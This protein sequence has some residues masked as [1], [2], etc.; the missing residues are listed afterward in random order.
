MKQFQ[1]PQFKVAKFDKDTNK[2]EFV[3][4][5][6]ERGFGLTLGNAF[7]RVL[8]SSLPGSSIYAIQVEGA[9]HEFSSLDGIVEDVTSIVLNLKGLVLNITDDDD[10]AKRTMTI[11]VKGPA[12]VKASDI[13]VPSDVEIV[14]PDLVIAHVAEGGELKMSL[15]ANKGRGYITCENNKQINTSFP[16]GTVMT[17]SSYSPIV[18]VDYEVE[19]TRVGH[20][21]HY[22]RLIIRVETNGSMNPADAVSLAANILVAHF[23]LFTNLG[24]IAASS[25]QVFSISSEPT[26]SKYADMTIE[27]LDLT[28]RSYN[29]LKRAGIS[30]VM[31]LAN[32]S[33]EE[34]MKVRNLGKKSL[35][36]V[37]EKLEQ[38]GL[39]FREI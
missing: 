17:D 19:P 5:P 35:K 10:E 31:E 15:Y 13:K 6:L 38:I 12:E 33:E 37:K 3:I 25:D 39:S 27:E 2:G 22:D 11:D 29:C 8:L 16:I 7:R 21:S 9:R 23:S 14:N 36:E 24:E 34:M 18:K 26:R 30:T 1:Q 28:V 32:R 20:D 4:E